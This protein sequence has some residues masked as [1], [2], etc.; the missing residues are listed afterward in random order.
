M[1]EEVD[2]EPF[3][4][5]AIGILISHQHDRAIPKTSGIIVNLSHFES[6]DLEQ[7][8]NFRIILD[9][10]GWCISDIQELSPQREN[11]V[12]VSSY[13]LKAAHSQTLG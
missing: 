1:V 5:R 3:D 4:V 8:L 12:V 6:N 2:Q 9:H 11:S 10:F 13:H 7:V